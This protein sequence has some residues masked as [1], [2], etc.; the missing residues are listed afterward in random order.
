MA[1]V[2]LHVEKVKRGYYIATFKQLSY[3]AAKE[4]PYAITRKYFDDL[5]AQIKKAPEYYLWTH[6]RWKHRNATLPKDAII[7]RS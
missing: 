4:R 2:Y 5:E 7:I 1:V 6:K 3:E